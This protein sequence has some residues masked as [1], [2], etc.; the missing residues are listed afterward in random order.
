[1]G[2][3]IYIPA[4]QFMMST[5]ALP[6]ADRACGGVIINNSG[7]GSS[8]GGTRGCLLCVQGGV[9][10]HSAMAGDHGEWGFACTDLSGDVDTPL[11]GRRQVRAWDWKTLWGCEE[12]SDG[13]HW[14]RRDRTASSFAFD[15]SA[16]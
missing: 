3:Q 8:G 7:W 2:L 9:V 10:L 14:K 6:P 11:R 4:R 16:L 1:M 13:A 5:F 15:D 12:S